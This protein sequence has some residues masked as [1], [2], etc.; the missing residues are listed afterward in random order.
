MRATQGRAQ[1]E[2]FETLEARS[3]LSAPLTIS[4]GAYLGGTQL[5]LVATAQDDHITIRRVTGGLAITDNDWS[6]TI[7]GNFKSIL[8]DGGAGN[9]SIRLDVSVTQDA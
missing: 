7:K 2:H 4:Q 3:L 1:A 6:T 9:D 5:K 8:V